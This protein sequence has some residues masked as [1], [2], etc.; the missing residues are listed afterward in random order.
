MVFS[1]QLNLVSALQHQGLHKEPQCRWQPGEV[2]PEPLPP[3]RATV[4]NT[5]PCNKQWSC[6]S[7]LVTAAGAPSPPCHSPQKPQQG[8]PKMDPKRAPTCL[9]KEPGERRGRQPSAQPQLLLW[10]CGRRAGCCWRSSH[11]KRQAG[12]GPPL[13]GQGPALPARIHPHSPAMSAASPLLG[14]SRHPAGTG[15]QPGLPCQHRN[16]RST[17]ASRPF[18]S[19]LTGSPRT[20]WSLQNL[21]LEHSEPEGQ[22]GLEDGAP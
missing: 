19:W 22:R 20:H 16:P 5:D 9:M 21:S 18:A 7:W 15:T 13:Q 2:I 14:T 17:A 10:E 3:A 8:I 11:W 4:A 6:M 1:V 12:T